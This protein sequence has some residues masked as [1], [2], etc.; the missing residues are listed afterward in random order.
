MIETIAQRAQ[1]SQNTELNTTN[2]ALFEQLSN[3]EDQRE[4]PRA[5][6]T[7]HM[8]DLFAFLQHPGGQSTFAFRF[9]TRLLL[10]G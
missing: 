3:E 10:Q 6:I 8:F 2:V 5:T 4:M 1:V 9:Q 7:P